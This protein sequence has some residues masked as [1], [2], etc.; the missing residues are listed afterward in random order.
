M[1]RQYRNTSIFLIGLGIA[2]VMYAVGAME[3]LVSL[4]G[5]YGYVGAL[6]LGILYASALTAGFASLAFVAMGGDLNPIVVAMLGGFGCM[7]A[8]LAIYSFVRIGIMTEL[9]AL[10][11]RFIPA[12]GLAKLRA[13][14]LRRGI[15]PLLPILGA[16]IIAS[17]FPD[18]LG[19]SLFAVAGVRIKALAAVA[20]VLNTI[21]I[22][23]L[24]TLGSVL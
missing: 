3:R 20:L 24:V 23:L 12:T 8:D 14:S 1:F 11:N 17:P 16:I 4:L 18:E 6:A 5:V 9:R 19:V 13:F 21:G 2:I 15:R 22:Y 7:V 10:A